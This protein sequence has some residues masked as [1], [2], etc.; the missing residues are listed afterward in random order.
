[1]VLFEEF[2]TLPAEAQAS[3]DAPAPMVAT[4][5]KVWL[6]AGGEVELKRLLPTFIY[7]QWPA[8]HIR[9]EYG[10]KGLGIRPLPQCKLYI[11]RGA[12]TKPLE[13]YQGLK[14]SLRRQYA[15]PYQIHVGELC[16]QP[17]I[18]I[19]LQENCL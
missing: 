13:R 7:D 18:L 17:F 5:R 8:D 4:G 11:Q 19:A 12:A 3:C 15:E 14:E 2:I 9:I 10:E 6:Q 1:M 16:C